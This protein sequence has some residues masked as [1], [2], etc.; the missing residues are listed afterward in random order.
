MNTFPKIYLE[1][2][3]LFAESVIVHKQTTNYN[4]VFGC[5]AHKG[6]M[7]PDYSGKEWEWEDD[8]D[9]TRITRERIDK[10]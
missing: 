6:F 8:Q 1:D 10:T 7:F 3:F 5:S 4:Q 2:L 9:T